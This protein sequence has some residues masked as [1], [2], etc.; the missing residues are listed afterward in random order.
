MI[1]CS[2]IKREKRKKRVGLFQ[3]SRRTLGI[4]EE[5]AFPMRARWLL[6]EMW[7]VRSWTS[8]LACLLGRF[9]MRA[10]NFPDGIE[11]SMVRSRLLHSVEKS[12][13]IVNLSFLLND[14]SSADL[15]SGSVIE[16]PLL[17]SAESS[18]LEVA[19]GSFLGSCTYCSFPGM[20]AWSGTHRMSRRGNRASPVFCQVEE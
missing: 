13:K 1:R 9:L 10:T 15:L 8:V 18:W 2:D 20:L 17:F 6:S 16:L 4:R 3:R 14:C 11:G 12:A 7:P 19:S 5:S